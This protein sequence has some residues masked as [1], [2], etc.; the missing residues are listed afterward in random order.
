MHSN[1]SVRQKEGDG[2]G[3][4]AGVEPLLR[5]FLLEEGASEEVDDEDDDNDQD[6]HCTIGYE[7]PLIWV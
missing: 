6:N 2:I 4:R 7:S 1:G 3:V 5:L